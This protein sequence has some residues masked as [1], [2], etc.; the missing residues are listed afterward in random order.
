MVVSDYK[1]LTKLLDGIGNKFMDLGG[2]GGNWSAKEKQNNIAAVTGV[3]RQMFVQRNENDPALTSW[4]TQFENILMQSY[5]EQSLYDFKQGFHRLDEEGKFDEDLFAKVIRTLTAMANIGPGNVG[6]VIIGIADN[7]ATAAR[8]E[9]KYNINSIRFNKFFITGVQEEA[10][11]YRHQ[12]DGYFQFIIQKLSTMPISDSDKEQIASN[13]RLINYYDKSV[14]IF[15]IKSG[16]EP[17]HF[18]GKYYIRR[19]PNNDEIPVSE[20]SNLYRRFFN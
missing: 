15:R 12:L 20:H 17:S 11:A 9:K 19:G 5:T 7:E 2:G 1:G 4:I 13:I 8:I 10:K 6:Y 3:I 16:K 14:L 18:D